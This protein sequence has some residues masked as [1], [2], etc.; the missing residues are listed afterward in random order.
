MI[1]PISHVL[2]T[3]I[4]PENETDLENRSPVFIVP[5]KT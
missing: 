3:V 4:Q 2:L 5:K 1:D